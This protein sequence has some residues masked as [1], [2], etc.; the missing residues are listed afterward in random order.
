MDFLFPRRCPV[1]HDIV[2]KR[3]NLCCENCREKLTYVREP[4]CLKCGKPLSDDKK[5]MCADCSK[6][7]RK[8]IEGR[9]IFVYDDIM[10]KSIYGFK[11]NGRQEYAKFYAKEIKKSLFEKIK[12]WNP[13][14]LIPIPIHRKKMKSRGY[15]QAYLIAKE[16][17]NL[18][19][20]PVINNYLIRVKNTTVQKNLDAHGRALNLKNA[21]KIGKNKVKLSSAI[22]IDDIYTTGATIDAATDVLRG[23]GIEN[24]YYISVS[25]GH[26]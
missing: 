14:A 23:S 26:D 3:E 12:S 24:I 9:S 11:Y 25:I 16:L 17:S 2:D 19:G 8:Y 15:N 13:D 21:F 10:R 4:W 18:T 5:I 20:I 7:N 6:G 1:C 22:L